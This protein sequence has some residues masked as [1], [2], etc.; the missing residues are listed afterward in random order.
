MGA[1]SARYSLKK[2]ALTLGAYISESIDG[3][4]D[5]VSDYGDLIDFV[6]NS[7]SGSRHPLESESES[8]PVSK[9]QWVT[10]LEVLSLSCAELISPPLARLF[11]FL[12]LSYQPRRHR[13]TRQARPSPPACPHAQ[14]S[15]R[16]STIPGRSRSRTPGP[17]QPKRAEAE[18]QDR[19]PPRS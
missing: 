10:G 19:N 3:D 11:C 17:A 8:E 14:P 6:S 4:D 12:S 2:L 13:P 9:P 16:T 7:A 18:V 5:D 1:H 15:T